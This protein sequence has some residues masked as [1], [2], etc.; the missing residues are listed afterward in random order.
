MKKKIRG[1]VS[2]DFYIDNWEVAELFKKVLTEITGVYPSNFIKD[3]KL[4]EHE[5]GY[6]GSGW[7]EVIREAN[8]HD[9]TILM[10]FKK[11]NE[12]KYKKD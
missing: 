3:G 2:Q 8:E 12:Y 10:L 6:H 5:R 4:M 11:I 9:S 7:D 1:S